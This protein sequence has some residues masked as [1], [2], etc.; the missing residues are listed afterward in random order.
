MVLT[1]KYMSGMEIRITNRVQTSSHLVK[2]I[3]IHI[4][5]VPGHYKLERL[6]DH[7]TT[8]LIRENIY[9]AIL[10]SANWYQKADFY[11][12]KHRVWMFFQTT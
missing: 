7:S 1:G 5:F 2:I 11:R 4:Y 12:F 6:K 8:I 3:V 9:F 10:R